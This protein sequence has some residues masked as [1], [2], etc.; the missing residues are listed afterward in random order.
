MQKSPCIHL[1]RAGGLRL[2]NTVQAHDMAV[3]G[4]AV[5]P[6]KKIV[7]TVSDDHKWK[8]WSI[9]RYSI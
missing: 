7:A 1:T 9:P 5:H 6:R 3:S 8:M 4:L 2:S